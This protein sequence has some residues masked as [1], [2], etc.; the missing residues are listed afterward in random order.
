[1]LNDHRYDVDEVLYSTA[2][3]EEI[4]SFHTSSPTSP[5]YILHTQSSRI[6]GSVPRSNM[7]N[8]NLQPAMDDS[9]V[10]KDDYE[11]SLIRKANTISAAAHRAVMGVVRNAKNEA[12]LE[13]IFLQYCVSRKAKTQAYDPIVG[14]GRNAAT[15]HYIH[16]D[17]PL[18]GR[19]LLLLDAGAEWEGYASD[20]T[21]TFPISGRWTKEAKDIYT[22]VDTMQRECIKRTVKGVDWRDTHSLAHRIAVKGLLQLGILYNGSEEEIFRAGTSK[23]FFPHGL[24]HFLGLD[25][26]DVEGTPDVKSPVDLCSFATLPTPT[27]GRGL[28][29]TTVRRTL[30]PRMVITVE[31]GMYEYFCEF[32]IKPYLEHAV[33]GNYINK[34]VLDKYWDVG[35]VRIEDDILVLEHGNENLTTAP[36]GSAMLALVTQGE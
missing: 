35:G 30:Q 22:I 27:V 10:Y 15:L 17:E 11:I 2:V 9:R 6:P 19:Q 12:E 21:R 5:V 28:Y 36:T 8:L 18:K 14:S 32:I 23:A 3:A 34:K 16:N 24:G 1:M 13:G 20:V 25:T 31:P 33:H 29:K 26:H 4:L 7:D